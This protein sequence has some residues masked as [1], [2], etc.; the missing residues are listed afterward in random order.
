MLILLSG[1]PGVGKSA[2]ARVLCAGGRAVHLRIDTIEGAVMGSTLAPASDAPDALGDVGCR[3][4]AAQARELSAGGHVVVG[5][6][7]NAVPAVRAAWGPAALVV[8]VACSDPGEHRARV[9]E[10]HRAVPGTPDWGMVIARRWVPWDRLVL[11]LDAAHAP[12]EALADRV[13]EAVA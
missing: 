8:E 3:V 7:L 2:L 6:A 13:W 10:R 4:A 5:D 12:P 9:E 11:R 1:L